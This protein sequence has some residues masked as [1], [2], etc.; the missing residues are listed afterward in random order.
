M[1]KYSKIIPVIALLALTGCDHM[2]HTEQN[3]LGGSAIGAIG[4]AAIGAATGGHAGTGALIGAGVGA[5]G[6]YLY[7]RGKYGY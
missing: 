4:G 2:S 3:V 7:D 6:G 5:A 1:K